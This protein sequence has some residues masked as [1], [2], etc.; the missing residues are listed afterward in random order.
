MGGGANPPYGAMSV[1]PSGKELVCK[2]NIRRF[3]SDY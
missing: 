2:A 1:Y 3:E